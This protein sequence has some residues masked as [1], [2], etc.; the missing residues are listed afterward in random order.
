[1]VQVVLLPIILGASLNQVA[2]DT[3]C[4]IEPFCPVVGVTATIVLV[5]AAVAQ[6]AGTNTPQAMSW[7]A[8]GS[9]MGQSWGPSDD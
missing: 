3:M 4:K 9:I 5:G 8:T 1:M 7:S 2:F 6:C